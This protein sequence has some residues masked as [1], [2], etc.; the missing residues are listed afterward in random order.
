MAVGLAGAGEG[1]PPD[2][3]AGRR[4][5]LRTQDGRQLLLEMPRGAPDPA[6][7]GAEQGPARRLAGAPLR[8]GLPL[9]EAESRRPGRRER[10]RVALAETEERAPE[11]WARGLTAQ[12]SVTALAASRLLRGI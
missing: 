10:R 8:Q 1:A 3:R 7:A 2:Q 5:R 12:F 4:W 9:G 11:A 6:V